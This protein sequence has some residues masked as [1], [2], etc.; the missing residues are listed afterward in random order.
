M[1]SHN[2][3]G[4][5]TL[6][7]SLMVGEAG[8]TPDQYGYSRFKLPIAPGDSTSYQKSLSAFMRSLLKVSPASS[9]CSRGL[10]CTYL[11]FSFS[12]SIAVFG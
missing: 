6:L 8:W 3:S 9:S 7:I 4:K 12:C 2:M 10:T 1:Q 11:S 5:V